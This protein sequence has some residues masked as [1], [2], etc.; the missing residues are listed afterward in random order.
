MT[1]LFELLHPFF[2]FDTLDIFQKY[3]EEGYPI[4]D[5]YA[6]DEYSDDVDEYD[7]DLDGDDDFE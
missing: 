7:D 6:D 4:E 3:D 2:T 5:E 1:V